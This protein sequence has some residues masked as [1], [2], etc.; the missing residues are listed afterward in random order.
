MKCGLKEIT[1]DGVQALTLADA[2]KQRQ[3]PADTLGREVDGEEALVGSAFVAHVSA[4]ENR[5]DRGLFRGRCIDEPAIVGER[6]QGRR[7]RGGNIGDCRPFGV[8]SS[9]LFEVGSL[10]GGTLGGGTNIFEP[11]KAAEVESWTSAI[12]A[13]FQNGGGDG[14]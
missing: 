9:R 6:S 4:A 7:G 3:G 8:E 14:G 2:L 12:T 10:N 1:E 13:P 11:A 5:S